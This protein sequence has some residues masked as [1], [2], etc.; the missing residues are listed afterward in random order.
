[1]VEIEVSDSN[2]SLSCDEED[3]DDVLDEEIKNSDD[4]SE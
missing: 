3:D 2:E 4:L 1:M